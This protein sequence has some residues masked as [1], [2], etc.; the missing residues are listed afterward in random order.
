MGSHSQSTHLF[1]VPTKEQKRRKVNDKYS[2]RGHRIKVIMKKKKNFNPFSFHFQPLSVVA[3]DFKNGEKNTI[4]RTVSINFD[5]ATVIFSLL[6]MHLDLFPSFWFAFDV[7]VNEN[8]GRKKTNERRE[9][10]KIRK[11][12]TYSI[13]GEK[14]VRFSSLNFLNFLA[15][16]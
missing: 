16:L 12:D 3:V 11:R 1:L 10:E 15:E 6:K 14:C 8:T 13:L 2:A 7:C 9:K 4:I 5:I